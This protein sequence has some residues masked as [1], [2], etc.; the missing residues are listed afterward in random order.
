MQTLGME[1]F[2]Y[3]VCVV[4]LNQCK[5]LTQWVYIVLENIGFRSQDDIAY[6]IKPANIP[7]TNT[8]VPYMMNQTNRIICFTKHVSLPIKNVQREITTFNTKY[9]IYTAMVYNMLI[10]LNLP[11]HFLL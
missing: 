7:E 1:S 10:I 2:W 3:C 11:I 6:I 8:G 5:A 9:H 4:G